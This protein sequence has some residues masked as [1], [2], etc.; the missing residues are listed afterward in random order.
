MK[1]V[2]VLGIVICLTLMAAMASPVDS[3]RAKKLASNF[4]NLNVL[5][6]RNIQ[7]DID[8][9]NLAPQMGLSQIFILQNKNGDGFVILSADDRVLPV[10][11]YAEHGRIDVNNI[12]ENFRFWLQGYEHE[13]QLA[14]D[15]HVA[16]TAT[17]AAEWT[18]LASAESLA[19]KSPTTVSPLLSTSWDQGS[20]YNALC[21]GYSWNRAPVGCVATAMAQVMKY[22]AYPPKGQG[23]HSYTSSYYNTTVSANFANAT[24]NWSSMPNS[25]YSSN[26][27]VATISYHCG[28]S[29]EM[30]YQPD[31]SGAQ[32]LSYYDDDHSAEHAL[33]RTFGYDNALH[34]ERKSSYTDAEWIQMLK[35]ELDASRPIIYTGYDSDNSSGHC[36]VCDGYNSSNQFHFNWGWSGSYDGYY[37][38]SSL[39]PG[40][41]GWGSGNGDYSYGQSALFG[42]QPP[43][44]TL[45][46]A[47]SISP[48]TSTTI[49]HGVNHSFTVT[50]KNNKSTTF[51][52]TLKLVI[53]TATEVPIQVIQEL[54]NVS[55]SG[56]STSSKTF[57]SLI[58]AVP[59]SYKL[60]LYYK[61][62]NS[63]KWTNVGIGNGSNR[64]NITVVLNPDSYE[65]NNTASSPY[66]FTPNFT[67]NQATINTVGSNIHV[68]DN[69]DYYRINL[70]EGYRYN[71][72]ATLYDSKNNPQQYSGNLQ[73]RFS[74]NGGSWSML[75]DTV[76]GSF[77]MEN[78]GPIVY[79]VWPAISG[80]IG[81]YLLSTQITRTPNTGIEETA[82]NSNVA[83]YPNPTTGICHV[84]CKSQNGECFVY[85]VFGKLLI[86][87][88]IEEENSELDLS[89]FAMGTYIVRIIDGKEKVSTHKIIKR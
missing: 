36:F 58:T 83:I 26:T 12:P 73:V 3:T 53:E 65:D 44:L 69:Y 11:G 38:L 27:Q 86:Y 25:V 43:A 21:P 32:T 1:K 48:A 80:T 19:P 40:S 33:Y 70:P 85:D 42:V 87:K 52:G 49:Q 60:T 6:S 22:W 35:T 23:S 46:S 74:N 84:E 62:N 63:T 15:N 66:V 9:Q 47:F 55:I 56:N 89:N 67:N 77:A 5:P 76:S 31:G 8:F 68:G 81:T 45:N 10:L 14:I 72:T 51:N 2:A 54:P 59:G 30:N 17:V 29:V 75:Q 39:T 50:I 64:A 16:Q 71:I 61:A 82:D 24:Y 7:Q 37:S 41:G 18:A 34:G 78:G 4:W 57:S 20:P 28:V 88:N 79:K 13:I